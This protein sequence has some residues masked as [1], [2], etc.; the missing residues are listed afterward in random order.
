MEAIT[1]L[2]EGLQSVD[3]QMKD[4]QDLLAALE[5]ARSFTVAQGW[6]AYIHVRQIEVRMLEDQNFLPV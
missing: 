6:Y 1:K 2:S 3:K 5:G 4:I